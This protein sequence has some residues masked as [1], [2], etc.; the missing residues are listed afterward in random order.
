M[1]SVISQVMLSP[2][3]PTHHTK[4]LPSS[5]AGDLLREEQNRE[6][7]QYGQLIRDHIKEGIIV[8][9]HVTIKLLENAMAAEIEKR[10][11]TT[12]AEGWTD[13]RARFLIDGFPRKMDQA[14][15]F[16]NT[17]RLFLRLNMLGVHVLLGVPILA[18]VVLLDYGRC[19][20]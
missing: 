2:T 9:M 4:T 8:P 12:P 7:S 19:H 3:T 20:A 5:P 6:G 13:G 17:V 14:L 1:I 11:K 15:E 18:C 16:D 10:K